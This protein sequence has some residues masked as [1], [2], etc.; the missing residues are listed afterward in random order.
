MNVSESGTNSKNPKEPRVRR[1][2][3][4]LRM[5]AGLA[6]LCVSVFFIGCI[7]GLVPDR[8]AAVMAG[9]KAL[10]EN[11]AVYS[12]LAAQKDDLELA[13]AGLK[14][15]VER[16]SSLL[17]AGLRPTM[18]RFPKANRFPSLPAY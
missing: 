5:S 17:S 15:A 16:N 8:D 6:S 14:A 4:A 18:S 11:L 7:L 2:W 10:C 1:Y 9:R 12:S 13:N 3:P